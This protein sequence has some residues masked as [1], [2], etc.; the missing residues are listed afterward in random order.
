[1]RVR[2]FGRVLSLESRKLMSYRADFWLNVLVSFATQLA[3]AYFVWLAVFEHTA[4]ETIG[5]FT[6]E[7]MVLYYILVILLGRIVR[8][9]ERDLGV[10]TDVY[11]GALTKYLLYP[12]DYFGFKYAAHLGD[13]VPG[14]VQLG[15]FA[16]LTLVFIELPADL[17]VTPWTVLMAAVAA[18]LANLLIFLLR[19]IVQLVA[20]W[21]DNVWSL[22]VMLRFSTEL[23]GGLMLPLTLFPQ[24]AQDLLAWTPFPY[25]FYVPV[26]VLLGEVGA[27]EWAQGLAIAAFWIVVTA[28]V[29]LRVWRRGTLSYTGVGI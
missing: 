17:A 6:F 14:M 27:A 9:Q 21:A 29:A 7:G 12:T 24:W 26:M 22:N 11:E 28:L 13:L 1:M 23:L 2:L 25:L 15:L 3:V 18:A 19:F 8:G 10:S 20:F 4:A 5:G 16:A